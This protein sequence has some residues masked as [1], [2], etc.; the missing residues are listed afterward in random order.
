M[1]NFSYFCRILH[2]YV[3]KN[4]VTSG[5]RKSV[6]YEMECLLRLDDEREDLVS[7]TNI[8][9]GLWELPDV[10]ELFF[11]PTFHILLNILLERDGSS[12][13]PLRLLLFF[14]SNLAES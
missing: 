4:K 8:D 3:V 10:N 6:V 14:L 11:L 2:A 1:I 5:V 12:C 7:P 9:V 13:A